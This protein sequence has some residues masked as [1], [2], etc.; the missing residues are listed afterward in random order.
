M[1]EEKRATFFIDIDGTIIRWSDRKPVE[2]AVE[3]VNAWYEAGHRIVLTTY[4]GDVIGQDQPRFSVASTIKELEDIGLKYHDI[5]FDC[6]SPRIVINDSG[7]GAI[8][9]PADAP[10]D[11][12]VFQGP[13]PEN[14]VESA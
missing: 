4:R 13:P 3:T 12:Q 6:P 1:S 11:Y 5:L 7:S 10:W 14:V 2:N 9:H 8:N